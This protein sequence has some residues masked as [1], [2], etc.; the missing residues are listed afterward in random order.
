MKNEYLDVIG[1]AVGAYTEEEFF[2]T[3]RRVKEQGIREHGFPR[4]TANLGML[5]AHGRRTELK[6]VF[7]DMLE[8]CLYGLP[9]VRDCETAGNEFSVKELLLC[10]DALQKA[11]TFPAETIEK[12]FSALKVFDPYAKYRF[13]AQSETDDIN[14]WAMFSV[15]S[16]QVRSHF[17]GSD[18]AAFIDRQLST[19]VRRFDENGMYRDPHEPMVYDVTTRLQ[20]ALA[21]EY[22]YDGRFRRELEENLMCSAGVTLYFQ[23][24]N[25]EFPYGGRSNQFL[26]CDMDYAALCEYYAA[27]LKESDYGLAKRFKRAAR[28]SYE[29][30]LPWLKQDRVTHIRNRYPNDSGYGCEGYGYFDKYMVT[31][32]SWAML[33]YLFA[34]DTIEE[35]E[36]DER[37]IWTSADCF[38]KLFVS[39]GNISIEADRN[40]DFMYDANGIGRI[41]KKGV[42]SSLILS[43][44]LPVKPNYGL[45]IENDRPMSLCCG[46]EAVFA[47]EQGTECGF[48][49]T[50]DASFRMDITLTDGKQIAENVSIRD[51][52]VCIEV[53]GRGNLRFAIPVFGFDGETH[54]DIRVRDGDVSVSYAGSTVFY[55]TD[56]CLTDTGKLYANRNGHYRLFIASAENRLTIKI[57]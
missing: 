18:E 38:H 42:P 53:L 17:C 46:D 41:H 57:R 31:T 8:M 23:S 33:A 54:T 16:E 49:V 30:I 3:I 51:G 56:G 12:W 50:G 10:I 20:A 4:L 5:I 34:D 2:G 28:K 37:F 15:A 22:G 1:M 19:Q 24:V 36:T 13:I 48:T 43:V 9:D 47:S 52:S 39:D 7:V 44:P 45:D 32:G 14:N 21:L 11:Q 27:K 25:G 26:M 40:A 55:E 35:A 6:D 29:S